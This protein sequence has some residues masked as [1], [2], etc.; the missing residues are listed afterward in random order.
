MVKTFFFSETTQNSNR[1]ALFLL[2]VRC[3]RCCTLSLHSGSWQPVWNFTFFLNVS[4]VLICNTPSAHSLLAQ[5]RLSDVG[6]LIISLICPLS[7]ISAL[8]ASTALGPLTGSPV[9]SAATNALSTP[10]PAAAGA[11]QWHPTQIHSLLPSTP[12][13]PTSTTTQPGGERQDRCHSGSPHHIQSVW[14]R[15]TNLLAG[16]RRLLRKE[17]CFFG[18]FSTLNECVNRTSKMNVLFNWNIQVFPSF[19]HKP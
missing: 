4:N 1:D 5:I 19:S 12:I 15:L 11:P 14:P 3:D 7:G 2:K 16:G 8:P 17:R 13:S 18:S 9:L 6:F 10:V